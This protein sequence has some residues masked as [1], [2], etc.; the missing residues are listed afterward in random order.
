[1]LVLRAAA[2][3]HEV[4]QPAREARALLDTWNV[5]P[6]PDSTR[7]YTG[8][9]LALY[10]Q[11]GDRRGETTALVINGIIASRVDWLAALDFYRRALALAREI[12]F[13]EEELVA[14]ANI[15]ESY[16]VRWRSAVQHGASLSTDSIAAFHDSTFVYAYRGLAR[17]RELGNSAEESSALS[18]LARFYE[19]RG[20][21]IPPARFRRRYLRLQ[22]D[23]ARR[24]S[25]KITE[26]RAMYFLA[27]FEGRV[28]SGDSARAYATRNYRSR[29]SGWRRGRGAV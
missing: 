20:V 19:S 8:E 6:L 12:N 3:F 1:M 21:A 13:P 11:A 10:R 26:I 22:I 24:T 29:T 5:T 23:V 4:R 16:N 25:N 9:A 14:L 27:E 7:D 28:G 18:R 17:A 2:L 15:A